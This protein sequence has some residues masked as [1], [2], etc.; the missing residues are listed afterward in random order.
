MNLDRSERRA[1]R[2]IEQALADSDPR[3]TELFSSFTLQGRGQ[4][5][6]GMEKI[7]AWPVQRTARAG[8]GA[9]PHGAAE[10]WR[11]RLLTMLHVLVAL[12]ALTCAFCFMRSGRS[13]SRTSAR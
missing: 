3:L 8:R 1:L 7:R 11:I 13:F 4:K 5:M 6:P 12:A 2:E 10:G 9:D